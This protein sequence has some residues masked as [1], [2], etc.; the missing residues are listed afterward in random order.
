MALCCFL[1]VLLTFV[2]HQFS[3]DSKCDI[4]QLKR[5]RHLIVSTAIIWAINSRKIPGGGWWHAPPG[6]GGKKFLRG[7]HAHPPPPDS[8]GH[9]KMLKNG[10]F[11]VIFCVF[12]CK[13]KNAVFALDSGPK[14][15]KNGRQNFCE[16]FESV[17]IQKRVVFRCS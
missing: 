14:T 9:P 11:R 10:G 8:G 4:V 6:K 2:M 13:R 17:Q 5:L 12:F 15:V 1:D 7:G 16:I 3:C